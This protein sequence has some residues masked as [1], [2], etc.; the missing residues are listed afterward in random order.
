MRSLAGTDL[1]TV[2]LS[3]F[4]RQVARHLGL[5]KK[6]LEHV[7]AQVNDWIKEAVAAKAQASA[8]TPEQRMAAVVGDLGAESAAAKLLVHFITISRVLP[9]TLAATDLRP[10][11][12]PACWAPVP[13]RPPPPGEKCHRASWRAERPGRT[14]EA[15]E[16]C[17]RCLTK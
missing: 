4:R 7:A 15:A 10:R 17:Y 2:T 11:L 14:I 1:D 12:A 13:R 5:G 16:A 3:K 8:Q 9:D 6:G